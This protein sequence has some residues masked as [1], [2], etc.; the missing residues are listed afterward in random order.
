MIRRKHILHDIA[1]LGLAIFGLYACSQDSLKD[2]AVV[3]ED[4]SLDPG[5]GLQCGNNQ[6]VCDNTCVHLED[7]PDHCGKCGNNCGEVLGASAAEWICRNNECVAQACRA[8]YH[9]QNG[10]CVPDDENSCAGMDCTSLPGWGSGKCDELWGC[11]AESCQDGYHLNT[12]GTDSPFC[13]DDAIQGCI[14]SDSCQ[15]DEGAKEMACNEGICTIAQCDLTAYH[16]DNDH[17]ACVKNTIE[18]CGAPF[19]NCMNY[20]GWNPDDENNRCDLNKDGVVS[21]LA[22]SCQSGYH[23]YGGPNA[24]CEMDDHENCGKHGGACKSDELCAGGSCILECGSEQKKCGEICVDVA[25]NSQNCG[26][27][28]KVCSAND[29]PQAASFT[30]KGGKCQAMACNT[31]FHVNNGQCEA[32][33]ENNCG[34]ASVNCHSALAGSSKVTCKEGKCIATAC[35]SGYHL[36]NNKCTTDSIFHC[37]S[38]EHSC[39]DT[40]VAGVTCDNGKCIVSS[41]FLHYHVYNN[42]CEPD[43]L[44][45]CGAHGNACTAANNMNAEC[46][47]ES[48]RSKCKDGYEDCDKDKTNGCEI[49]LSDYKLKSC[50]FC[51]NEYEECGYHYKNSSVRLCVKLDSTIARAYCSEYCNHEKGK[52]GQKNQYNVTR[53]SPGQSCTLS[54]YDI[55]CK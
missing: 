52:G 35:A 41:C 11:E 3:P 10:E 32:D 16:W 14:D 40:G 26:D 33:N 51:E 39:K 49:K 12:E 17:T 7:D 8:H 43:S 34:A 50:Y 24:P 2:V 19:V 42:T 46:W 45:N 21:C 30:C 44:S 25:S 5:P 37:G 54:G 6:V 55:V 36:K 38:E 1:A 9:L 18:E 13:E 29:V 31:G 48:C 4:E 15:L 28:G 23:V 22:N 27:C 20:A 47:M 53:C